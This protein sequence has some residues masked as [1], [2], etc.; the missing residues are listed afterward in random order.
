[1]A[2]QI[3]SMKRTIPLSARKRRFRREGG[4]GSWDSR[5]RKRPLRGK[6]IKDA[7]GILMERW[8]AF[9]KWGANCTASSV[10]PKKSGEGAVVGNIVVGY[11][12]LKA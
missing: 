7:F 3:E 4:E 8:M 9:S 1:L 6:K 10:R 5:E 11:L 2:P 12:L